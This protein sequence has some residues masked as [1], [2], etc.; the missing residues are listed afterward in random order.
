MQPTTYRKTVRPCI[1]HGIA[2]VVP[3]LPN[4]G[5][6]T[7]VTNHEHK[8]KSDENGKMAGKKKKRK[9]EEKAMKEGT[10]KEGETEGETEEGETE[11]G[12]SEDEDSKDGDSGDEDSEDGSSEDGD[13]EEGESEEGESEEEESEEEESEEGESEEGETEG[14]THNPVRACKVIATVESESNRAS[15]SVGI[16]HNPRKRKSPSVAVTPVDETHT[17]ALN[18]ELRAF[19]EK[20]RLMGTIFPSRQDMMRSTYANLEQLAKTSNDR[21]KLAEQQTKEIRKKYNELER[22]NKQ[23]GIS[24][25][26]H[27]NKITEQCEQRT[28]NLEKRIKQVEKENEESNSTVVYLGRKLHETIDNQ[29]ELYTGQEIDEMVRRAVED[30]AEQNGGYRNQDIH[31]SIERWVDAQDEMGAQRSR[32]TMR[33]A[34]TQQDATSG[35]ASNSLFLPTTPEKRMRESPALPSIKSSRSSKSHHRSPHLRKIQKHPAKAAATPVF[36]ASRISPA[37]QCVHSPSRTNDPRLSDT[38][39]DSESPPTYP[40]DRT[41]GSEDEFPWY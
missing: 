36:Q 4:V 12:D 34:S 25:V 39:R 13:S 1:L 19:A 6:V 20:I 27:C 21:A 29:A 41:E 14:K 37:F 23:D 40:Y 3:R 35:Q 11:E 26:Q 15:T 16:V 17:D 8:T 18:Q 24:R 31:G 2:V 32:G 22:K 33:T 7:N 30:A 9:A 10:F 38:L 5:H 28:H